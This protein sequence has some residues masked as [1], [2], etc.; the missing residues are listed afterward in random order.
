M[1]FF[2]DTGEDMSKIDNYTGPVLNFMSKMRRCTSFLPFEAKS[3]WL[4]E[5]RGLKGMGLTGGLA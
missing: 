3:F 5:H 4:A 2:S 1:L